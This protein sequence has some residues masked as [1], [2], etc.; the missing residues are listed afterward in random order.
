[1]RQIKT[2]QA[3]ATILFL[4]IVSSGFFLRI[5]NLN[6]DNFWVDEIFSF[7]V[8][9]PSISLKETFSRNNQIEIVPI[10]FNLILKFFFKIFGYNVDIARFVSL[11]FGFLSIVLVCKLY[12]NITKNKNNLLIAFLL[13]F[14][15]FLI[16]Y[17]QELR[18]YSLIF[19]LVSINLIYFVKIVE[20]NKLNILNLSLIHI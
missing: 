2:S 12:T 16:G 3:I 13:S 15:I 5:Y 19:F 4:T 17:S 6:F 7:W 1:M 9:D 10:L 20:D 18:V 8:A 14:N 11:F